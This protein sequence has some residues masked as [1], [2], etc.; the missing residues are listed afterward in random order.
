MLKNKW[1]HWQINETIWKHIW[2]HNEKQWQ[3]DEP[4][5]TNQWEINEN[6]WQSI[7]NPCQHNEQ[8]MKNRRKHLWKSMND[9]ETQLK[10]LKQTKRNYGNAIKIMKT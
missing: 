8:I 1:K 2:I 4:T 9:A 7:N 3:F 5:M 10:H 6:Q